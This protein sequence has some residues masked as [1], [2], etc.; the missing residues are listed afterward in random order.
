MAVLAQRK[1]VI[2][3]IIKKKYNLGNL[4][5]HVK[6]KGPRRSGVLGTGWADSQEFY[7]HFLRSEFVLL[8]LLCHLASAMNLTPKKSNVV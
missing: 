2:R 8:V 5:R 6:K 7:H 4:S 1:A 3:F